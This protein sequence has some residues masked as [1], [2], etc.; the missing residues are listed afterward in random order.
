MAQAQ[1]AVSICCETVELQKERGMFPIRISI[2]DTNVRPVL[3]KL[4]LLSD[5]VVP[6]NSHIH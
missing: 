1:D 2:V 4:V 3:D 6:F 5:P